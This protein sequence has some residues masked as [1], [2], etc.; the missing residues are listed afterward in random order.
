M[1]DFVR[2][3][4]ASETQDKNVGL[5]HIGLTAV[6]H[7]SSYPGAARPKVAVLRVAQALLPVSCSVPKSCYPRAPS[8]GPFPARTC[9]LRAPC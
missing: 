5:Q 1:R 9:A 6:V 8:F 2:P 4:R 7:E 3:F